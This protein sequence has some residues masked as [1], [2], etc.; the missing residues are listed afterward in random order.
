[1]SVLIAQ[2]L[3]RA[4]MEVAGNCLSVS[5]HQS[6]L[7]AQ[8]THARMVPHAIKQTAHVQENMSAEQSLHV[9]RATFL[10]KN[11]ANA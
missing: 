4:G 1:M 3:S 5:A 2:M 11:P 9:V 10:T 8:R 7:F 6:Q